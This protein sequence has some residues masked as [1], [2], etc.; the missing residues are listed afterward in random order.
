MN[1]TEC[2]VTN[3]RVIM[4]RERCPQ[5]NYT[6][7][8]VWT[9]VFEMMY[10]ISMREPPARSTNAIISLALPSTSSPGLCAAAAGWRQ[11]AFC[12]EILP[13]LLPPLVSALRW[14][15]C[16]SSFRVVQDFF[17]HFPLYTTLCL[18]VV[19]LL[20]GS[21]QRKWGSRFG[22][23]VVVLCSQSQ[24]DKDVYLC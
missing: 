9:S 18:C 1:S 24:G 23:G 21:Q 6:F 17:L 10:S 19:P 8:I 2:K 5:H 15:V 20:S 13:R 7:E 22:V 12:A 11:T 16:E 4:S 3:S 14:P